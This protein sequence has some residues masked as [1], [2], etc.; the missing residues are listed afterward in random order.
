M[1]Q[2]KFD[3]QLTVSEIGLGTWQLGADWGEV[4]D[5]E[6][7]AILETAV[8]SGVTFFDTADVYGLGRSENRIREFIQRA[9]AQVTVATKLGRFPEPG[10]P[11][12]FTPANLT[13][14]VEA[15]LHR[16]GVEALDLT[17]LH[18][19]PIPLLQKYQVFDT[20][21]E[22]KSAGKIQRFGASIES[23]EE[24]EICLQEDGLSSLQI[25][26]NI[27]RQKP[28]HTLFEAAQQKGVALIVR[29][30]L[31]S[32]LLSGCF[33]EKTTFGQDDHRHYN[34]NG[35]CFNVGETFAGI[36]FQKG[37]ELTQKLQTI[38]PPTIPLA[39]L[40]LRWILDFEAVTVIIPG[41]TKIEQVTANARASALA[42]LSADL[43]ARLKEF[44]QA[45]VQPHIRGVY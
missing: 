11:D 12:N 27:Y 14:H 41:A 7:Q 8:E 28:I 3:K 32:G 21:R 24:A 26:F 15:S 44:Y 40:A 37:L 45:E 23:M 6:A 16:L 29:L 19:I 18:C 39:E 35:A 22:L 1:K 30:P 38:V 20:L 25:I 33:T 9:G 36:P 10:W 42:P 4:S 34:Q 17:Q 13:R 31:A 43:H 5:R 2:R